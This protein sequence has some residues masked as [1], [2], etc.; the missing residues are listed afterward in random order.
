MNWATG[1]VL[2]IVLLLVAVAVVAL[3]KGKGKCDCAGGKQKTGGGC[4]SCNI[5]CPFKS[6]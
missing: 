1:I 5:D 2:F 3:R 6:R 4:A